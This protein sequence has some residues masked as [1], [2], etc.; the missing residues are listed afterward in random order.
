MFRRK[1][2]KPSEVLE[3]MEA[4][5][6]VPDART[7]ELLLSTF[8]LKEWKQGEPTRLMDMFQRKYQ[9]GRDWKTALIEVQCLARA[10]MAQ[11]CLSAF[12]RVASL[13][14]RR[15]A[16]LALVEVQCR[17]S[18]C[19]SVSDSVVDGIFQGRELP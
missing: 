11:E 12:M 13:V 10:G 14:G 6:V 4:A 16:W 15:D 1:F 8:T 3:E 5:N 19:R 2:G 18:L 9:V 17:W 7:L